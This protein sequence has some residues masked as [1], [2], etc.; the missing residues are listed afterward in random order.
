[1][2][3][4]RRAYEDL[5][6][7]LLN[8]GVPSR[9]SAK[10][11]AALDSWHAAFQR[12][13]VEY[14]RE[15]ELLKVVGSTVRLALVDPS[16]R[17]RLSDIMSPNTQNIVAQAAKLPGV[18]LDT[19]SF[20]DLVRSARHAV[21]HAVSDDLTAGYIKVWQLSPT[22]WVGRFKGRS[23]ADKVILSKVGQHLRHCYSDPA[24]VEHYAPRVN[25]FTAFNRHKTR[26][27]WEPVWT[28]AVSKEDH[29][30]TEVR[31]FGNTWAAGKYFRTVQAFVAHL[32]EM[33]KYRNVDDARSSWPLL[34]HMVA[35]PWEGTSEIILPQEGTTVQIRLQL[36]EL[37]DEAHHPQYQI[38]LYD[39]NTGVALATTRLFRIESATSG[40]Y[41]RARRVNPEFA[42]GVVSGSSVKTWRIS[43]ALLLAQVLA[44]AANE[45][46]RMAGTRAPD[47]SGW[48]A[49][50]NATWATPQSR[51]APQ[52]EEDECD[53]PEC[54]ARRRRQELN[55]SDD[56]YDD[57]GNSDSDYDYEDED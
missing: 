5:V 50:I 36:T 31:D 25:L 35:R 4:G 49:G 23:P 6:Q 30:L 55:E 51:V 34:E 12:H 18:A 2:R 54:R 24:A 44:S 27:K 45:R 40:L 41:E 3:R 19:W 53:C 11:R 37:L 1:M 16:V 43:D 10:F 33:R 21:R 29:R 46:A 39:T 8:A 9:H 28:L 22:F 26:K 20:R 17:P 56:D 52:P 38:M 48:N 47:L 7:H 42:E 15:R 14:R 13:G 32:K 57:Y